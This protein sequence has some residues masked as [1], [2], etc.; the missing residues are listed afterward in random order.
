MDEPGRRREKER[1][2]LMQLAGRFFPSVSLTN[3]RL[4][5]LPA[6]SVSYEEWNAK[7]DTDLLTDSLRQDVVMGI[8]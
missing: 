6:R 4:W 1:E 8:N 3:R 7:F 5:L 2:Y